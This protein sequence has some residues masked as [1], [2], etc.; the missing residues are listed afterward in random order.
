MRIDFLTDV[1]PSSTCGSAVVFRQLVDSFK[2]RGHRVS[3]RDVDTGCKLVESEL[4]F[5]ADPDDDVSGVDFK[6]RWSKKRPDIVYLALTRTITTSSVRLA[7]S[8]EIPVVLDLRAWLDGEETFDRLAAEV[9]EINH[10]GLHVIIQD[11][12]FAALLSSL[13]IS[14]VSLLD[15]GVDRRMFH[16][17]RRDDT[18]RASWGISANTVVFG[19]AGRFE[20]DARCYAMLDRFRRLKLHWGPR[21]ALVVAGEG[22]LLPAIRDEFPDVVIHPVKSRDAKSRVFAS[23]DVLLCTD[24][25]CVSGQTFREALSSGTPV[26]CPCTGDC[27]DSM[28]EGDASPVHC[29]EPDD[30]YSCMKILDAL[31]GSA[32]TDDSMRRN[33]REM[34]FPMDSRR[35]HG[36]VEQ[37]L[38]LCLLQPEIR[39]SGRAPRDA[40]HTCRTVFL[41]DIHLG[42]KDC[43]ADECRRFLKHIRADKIVLVGDI[44]DAWALSRGS[45]WRNKHGR[46]VRALLRKMDREQTEIVYLRG[47][48]DEVMEKFMPMTLGKL[49][50]AGEYVHTTRSGRTYLCIH[51][52]GF[53]NVCSHFRWLA[54]LGSLGYDVLL[55][56]NRFYNRF[57]AWRGKEYYSVSKAI[58]QK[59]KSAVNFIGDYEKQLENM[60]RRS[61]C[62]GMI[63]GHIHHG[64]DKWIGNIHYMNC[65]DWVESMTAIIEES[66]GRLNLIQ[67][68]EW[69]RRLTVEHSVTHECDEMS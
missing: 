45:V 16:P 65:G 42:T 14:R 2:L 20:P 32:G 28:N 3:S 39:G 26:V 9:A 63:A 7:R 46:L 8:L 67:Y 35:I 41:S 19:M 55:W 66:D 36:E 69:M 68:D 22:R 12:S 11:E 10:H 25:S 37:L 18:L 60:A 30:D 62:D 40:V 47:N 52:D 23:I 44:I 24:P 51:G 57:R 1:G 31:A 29:F 33:A 49:R 5:V 61:R 34:T 21:V 48:H 13:G 27:A 15:Q 64:A 6:S 50:L 56:I 38:R 17:G 54:L 53:D 58:K 4:A 59:V 43:K